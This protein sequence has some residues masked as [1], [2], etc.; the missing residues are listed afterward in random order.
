MTGDGV[1]DRNARSFV[2]DLAA[3]DLGAGQRAVFV[4]GGEGD[5]EG[6]DLVRVPRGGQLGEATDRG[7]L[8]GVVDRRDVRADGRTHVAGDAGLE[9]GHAGDGIRIEV[10]GTDLVSLGDELAARLVEEHTLRGFGQK[11]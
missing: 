6:Q 2:Q 1:V 3:E 10:L 4:R 8:L 7:Q 9:Q 5:V 11:P